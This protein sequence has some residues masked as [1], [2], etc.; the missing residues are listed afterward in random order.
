M[1]AVSGRSRGGYSRAGIRS[2]SARPIQTIHLLASP[3]S[4]Y[5][6][7]GIFPVND[8]PDYFDFINAETYGMKPCARCVR[9]LKAKDGA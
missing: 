3:I 1:R 5:A 6:M 8:T 7:C 9:S 2:Q 4:I